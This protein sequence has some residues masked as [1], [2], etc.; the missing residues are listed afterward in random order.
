MSAVSL[1][2]QLSAYVEYLRDMG[3]YDLYHR[4]DPTVCCRWTRAKTSHPS[5]D[6]RSSK[7]RRTCSR[8]I[9]QP[10]F[11]AA[12]QSADP[13]RYAPDQD[14]L[15]RWLNHL[16]SILSLPC[17]PSTFPRRSFAAALAAV[18]AEIGDCTRC[19]L[20]YAGTQDHRLRG[21]RSQRPAHVR[22]RR[23]GCR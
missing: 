10:H 16:P 3:V 23:T 19:P 7:P 21:R 2:Q 4:P 12:R 11:K 17:Q 1:E 5:P 22:W 15:H 13:F 20:A 6:P 8:P 9:D 14:F 18:Q